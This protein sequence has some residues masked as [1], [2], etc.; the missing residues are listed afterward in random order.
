MIAYSHSGIDL[1][2]SMVCH[3]SENRGRRVVVIAPQ[4]FQLIVS[5]P[6]NYASHEARTVMHLPLYAV[7]PG[8]DI[9]RSQTLFD[10][11]PGNAWLGRCRHAARQHRRSA[12]DSNG[13]TTS[14]RYLLEVLALHGLR[15]TGTWTRMWF[16][17]CTVTVRVRS[18]EANRKR[19]IRAAH[20]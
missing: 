14:F 19:R 20:T 9:M 10:H 6:R 4:F 7:F 12:F 15:P 18:S 1:N 17:S 2:S 13:Q 8:R 5:C 11:R 3:T 16:L